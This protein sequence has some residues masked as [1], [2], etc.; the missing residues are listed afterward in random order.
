NIENINP[1][2]PP[3]KVRITFSIFVLKIFT[4][5]GIFKYAAFGFNSRIFLYGLVTTLFFG[6]VSGVY[7]A[8]KMSLMHPVSALR[9]E[10]V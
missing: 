9:G 5:S 2:N 10:N 3:S 1:S 4:Y 6:V 7:P 8:W